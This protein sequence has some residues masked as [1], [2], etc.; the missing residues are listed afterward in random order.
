[1][2]TSTAYVLVKQYGYRYSFDGVTSISHSLNLRIATDSESEDWTDYVNNARNEP[3]VVTLSVTASDAN[4]PVV[5]W[6]RQTM[7]SLA[8]IKEAR[9]LCK[10]VTSL[11]TYDNMLLTALNVTQDENCP[12]GW[13]GTLTFT[14][15]EPPPAAA[16]TEDYSSTPVSTGSTSTKSVGSQRGGSGGSVLKTILRDAGIKL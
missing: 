11:R 3:D 16:P 13:I 15:S 12:D 14:H 1:M 5:G 6:S 2:A 8:Q 7:N 9:L 10:V 4:V